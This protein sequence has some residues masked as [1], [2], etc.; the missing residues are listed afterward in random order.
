MLHYIEKLQTK[1]EYIRK[2][3]L[4]AVVAVSMGIIGLVWVSTFSLRFGGE[5][6]PEESEQN[7]SPFAL[8]KESGKTFSADFSRGVE[9]LKEQFGQ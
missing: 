3:I 6:S 9:Q 8:I 7:P 2:R 1:P 5:V 4:I